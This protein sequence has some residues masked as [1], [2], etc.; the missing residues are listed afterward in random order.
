M[1]KNTVKDAERLEAK[2]GVPVIATIPRSP[3]LSRLSKNKIAPNRLLA[4]VDHNGV[5]YEAI[6][7]LRTHLMFGIPTKGIA[8]EC[9]KVILISGES[10]GVGKSFISANLAEV[11]GQL[12]SKV[13]VIDADMRLGE[14][15]KIFNM[16]QNNGLAD[17]L[18]QENDGSQVVDDLAN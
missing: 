6:K 1:L 15:H 16:N 9:A 5:S 17:Y 8:G 2:T 4:Y 3:S 13:L 12:H 18:S 11:F 10:P 7:S 14:L